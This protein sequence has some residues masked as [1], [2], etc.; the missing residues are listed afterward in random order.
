[1]RDEP[2]AGAF[3]NMARRREF[4]GEL[5]LFQRMML[6]WR[7]LHP[8][9]AVHVVYVAQPLDA[10]RVRGAV[11]A[12]LQAMGIADFA[13][14]ATRRRYVY[15]GG[16]VE[17]AL[18]VIDAADADLDRVLSREIGAE[19]NRPFAIG[20][21]L[22]FFAV[23]SPAGFHLALAYDHF[24]AGG[25][26]AAALLGIVVARIVGAPVDDAALRPAL[27]PATYA[28]LVRRHPAWFAR[29]LA[30]MPAIARD[31]KS[32]YRCADRDPEDT[33]NAFEVIRVDAADTATLR[34]RARAQGVTLHD[35]VVAIMLKTLA[36]I[37]A[38]RVREH[39]RREIGVA[40]IVNIR[41]DFGVETAG[42][43]GQFLASMRI[44]HAVPDGV[45]I[46]A[47]ARDV[48]AITSPIKRRRLYLRTL[49][50]LLFASA[51]W[52]FMSVGQR[53]R[54]YAK[55]HPAWAG[56]SMLDV[57]PLWPPS[58]RP[59]ARYTRGV[60]TGPLTPAVLAIST[61]TTGMSVGVSWRRA[62][63]PDEFPHRLQSEISLCARDST[64]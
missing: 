5:N 64:S 11:A 26:S 55:H 20:A 28:S 32:V 15:R 10:I 23:A 27:Y 9:N 17:P 50:G 34:R 40:S 43:F 62:V 18:E 2:A 13:L 52:R 49:Y 21:P 19:L 53:L 47:L 57:D 45:G 39:R 24:I 51:A 31:S 22:R 58:L 38:G 60:S 12:S 3:L 41:K 29:A 54:F 56:V 14:D 33:H 7:E 42:A 59:A 44:A 35:L 36:P 8:Y 16:P 61:T 25:D 37:A 63:L 46:D 30:A 1:M 4:P 6:R 48:R